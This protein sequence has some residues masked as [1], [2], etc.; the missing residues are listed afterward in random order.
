MRTRRALS[1]A[2]TPAW[3]ASLRATMSRPDVSRSRRWTMP[4][5]ATPAMPAVVVAAGEQRVDERALPV[6]RGRV[7][8]EAR[9]LV[10]D[11]Q[12][13]VLVDD[14]DRDRRVGLQVVR[15]LGGRDLQRHRAPAQHGVRAQAA[16]VLVREQPLGG[17]LLDVRARQPR[18]VGHEA[19]NPPDDLA[20]GHDE[21]P[22]TRFDRRRRVGRQHHVLGER[23][24]QLV[25]GA[26]EHV[27]RVGAARARRRPREVV[28][29]SLSH[30]PGPPAPHSASRGT[31]AIPISSRMAV[32]I[33]ASA[34]L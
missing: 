24:V 12:V 7:H 15:D 33:A 28:A 10:D 16:A 22:R 9:R 1:C 17:E 6:A 3:A 19:V 13:I 2:M 34:A 31:I 23:V 32:V 30:R 18:P 29:G 5:R 11:E 26:L 25:L 14:V 4:G 21:R 8:D 27:V 20:L